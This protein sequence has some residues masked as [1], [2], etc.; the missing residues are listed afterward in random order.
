MLTQIYGIT[1]AEDAVLVNALGP[2]HVG[3]V[4]DEGIPSWDTVDAA[5]LRAI[6][7]ELSDVAVVALSLSTERD[8]ILRTVEAVDPAW[9]HLPHAAETLAPDTVARLQEALAPRRLML[10]IPVRDEGAIALARRFAPCAD[11]LLTD[12]PHPAT[13]VVGATGHT[14]DWSLSARVVEAADV[15]VFLAGGLGPEN[16]VEA[17]RR[18]RPAGVD[19]ET[20]TSRDDDRR[21]KDPERVRLFL[22]RARGAAG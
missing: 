20:R 19:S 2:D 12:T 6:R 17:I 14:H 9:V 8:R 15:P 22:E 4:L 3:L 5:T 13:G 11:A 1:T 21:R 10:T 16:V 7:P 18:T